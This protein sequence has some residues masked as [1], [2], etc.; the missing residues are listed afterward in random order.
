[1]QK[2]LIILQIGEVNIKMAAMRTQQRLGLD[3]SYKRCVERTDAFKT[4]GY[5]GGR[6]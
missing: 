1:M 6:K 3:C 4:C 2:D 5:D